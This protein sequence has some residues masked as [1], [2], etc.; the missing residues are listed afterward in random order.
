MSIQRESLAA[1]GA[2]LAQQ[3]GGSS[4]NHAETSPPPGVR[5]PPRGGRSPPPL[6]IMSPEEQDGEDEEIPDLGRS[7]KRRATGSGATNR[8]AS[9]ARSEASDEASTIQ[10]TSEVLQQFAT[11]IGAAVAQ[12]VGRVGQGSRVGAAPLIV[13]GE[14]VD[15]PLVAMAYQQADM[16]SQYLGIR[17]DE[18]DRLLVALN[19]LLKFGALKE[20][21]SGHFL[22]QLPSTEI[23]SMAKGQLMLHFSSPIAFLQWGHGVMDSLIAAV[24]EMDEAALVAHVPR[25][26][27]FQRFLGMMLTHLTTSSWPVLA[28]VAMYKLSM[29]RSNQDASALDD[30]DQR[31][32]AAARHHVSLLGG[33]ITSPA[34]VPQSQSRGQGDRRDLP[35]FRSKGDGWGHRADPGRGYG[36][37]AYPQ[38]SFDQRAGDG[39][40]GRRLFGP[41]GLPDNKFP[42]RINVRFDPTRDCQSCK[43]KGYGPNACGNPQCLQRHDQGKG[44]GPGRGSN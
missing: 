7:G 43:T 29:Y 31:V 17:H 40:R 22:M 8:P 23:K 10:L 44:M 34:W 21:T 19:Q 15:N 9:R 2:L 42:P 28:N 13:G 33:D 25:V 14:G 1:L 12:S 6:D 37:G 11:S 38:P 27:H 32:F 16:A 39:D 18:S 4:D 20:V 3:G 41:S 24:C 35:Q 26:L 5:P 36:Y 30:W